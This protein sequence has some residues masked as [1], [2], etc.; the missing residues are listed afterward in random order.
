[1]NLPEKL[2][3]LKFDELADALANPTKYGLTV[4]DVFA[5]VDL[6]SDLTIK[7]NAATNPPS[8]DER[9]LKLKKEFDALKIKNEELISENKN[10]KI[11]L[12]S[13]Q[14]VIFNAIGGFEEE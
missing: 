7:A 9:Y 4:Y 12:A 6:F 8:N 10:L 1:M 5:L 3:R 13:I 14:G 11:T 2:E